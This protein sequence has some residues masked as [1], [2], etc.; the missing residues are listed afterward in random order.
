MNIVYI[1]SLGHS[2]STLLDKVLS[3][4]NDILGLGEITNVINKKKKT[5]EG[6]ENYCSCG[7][8]FAKC[9]FWSGFDGKGTAEEQYLSLFKH[10][11][12]NIVVDSSKNLGPL[13]TLQELHRKKKINLKIIY[14]IRDFRGWAYS[15]DKSAKRW[16]KAS[17]PFLHYMMLW[18][19]Q[20][21]NMQKHIKK[22]GIPSLQIG[23]EEL[24]FDTDNTLS[25]IWKFIGVPSK[26][27]SLDNKPTSH[28]AYGNRMK[29]AGKTTIKY[30][31]NWCT[32][33]RLT[34]YSALLPFVFWWNKKNVY[35]YLRNR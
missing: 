3:H 34:V 10:A 35:G 33:Y 18:Y 17:R 24:C 8:T 1:A 30:D 6:T 5:G 13:R 16:N 12:S 21:K 22:S 29:K 9:P 4:H 23:Y 15:M 7:K 20:N 11:K 14:L 19:F 25:K 26:K 27:F 2:G 28:I 31:A 32:L